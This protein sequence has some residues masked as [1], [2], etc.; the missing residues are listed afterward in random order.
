M[1]API[2]ARKDVRKLIEEARNIYTDSDKLAE[3]IQDIVEIYS[4]KNDYEAHI[5][6]YEDVRVMTEAYEIAKQLSGYDSETDTVTIQWQNDK[7]LSMP[8]HFDKSFINDMW[9]IAE[10]LYYL[11]YTTAKL[12]V[13]L[14]PEDIIRLPLQQVKRRGGTALFNDACKFYGVTFS[15]PEKAVSWEKLEAS[16]D[17]E[18]KQIKELFTEKDFNKFVGC[19]YENGRIK[20]PDE[21]VRLFIMFCNN[22]NKIYKERKM[23]MVA[24]FLNKWEMAFT[25]ERTIQR[26][27]SVYK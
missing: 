16:D 22:K 20:E 27:I 19:C 18:D 7:E 15:P 10:A 12:P 9:G 21:V 5:Q 25:T 14:S 11:F 24:R 3:Y 17:V 2:E 1:R 6:L 26:Y 4:Y 13:M 23:S 8:L